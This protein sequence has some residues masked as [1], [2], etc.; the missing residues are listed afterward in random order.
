MLMTMRA[1]KTLEERRDAALDVARFL[2][3]SGAELATRYPTGSSFTAVGISDN[4]DA[5]VVVERPDR[6]TE[7][8]HIPSSSLRYLGTTSSSEHVMPAHLSA[9]TKVTRVF[10]DRQGGKAVDEVIVRSGEFRVR[11]WKSKKAQILG[12]IEFGHRTAPEHEG[13]RRRV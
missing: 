10:S 4:G 1:L 8:E 12:P 5:V 13:T 11:K 6:S 3:G 9:G 7:V 2:A